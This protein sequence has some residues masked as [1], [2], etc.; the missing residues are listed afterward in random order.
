MTEAPER[1]AVLKAV[2][3]HVPF[4]GW[5]AQAFEA[6]V[7]DSGID[8]ARASA[9]FPSGIDE[10]SAFFGRW[11]AARLEE[12]LAD[13]AA[14][15]T[16]VR[17]RIVTGVRTLLALLEPHREA[18]SRLSPVDSRRGAVHG[19]GSLYRVVDTIWRAAG[20][21]STDFSF[22][23][24]RGLLSGVVASTYFYWLD[25]TSEDYEDTW[26]FLDRRIEDVMRIQRMRGRL[27]RFAGSLGAPLDAL[28]KSPI[29]SVFRRRPTPL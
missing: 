26:A 17:K 29:R 22:Y 19:L 23:T 12:E 1:E 15:E 28:R 9:L 20:D 7:A 11:I 14:R 13:L 24:K 4:D 8:P 21:C 27:D 16:S 3:R 5:S 25:D 6:G 18:A 10:V 2:L